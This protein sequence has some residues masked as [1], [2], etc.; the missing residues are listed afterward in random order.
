[1]RI[2][3]EQNQ[4]KTSEY[5]FVVTVSMI[6]CASCQQPKGEL[7]HIDVRKDYPEK[8]LILTDIADV[9]YLHPSSDDDDYLYNGLIRAITANTIV[10]VDMRSGD[11][12]F[13]SKDGAPKSRFNRRGN[14]PREYRSA[15]RVLFDEEVAFFKPVL[16]S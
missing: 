6:I 14:G 2:F 12:L 7:P 5:L 9:S 16:M 1:V 13:F 4:M 3:F 8:E 15:Y 10:I 11:I